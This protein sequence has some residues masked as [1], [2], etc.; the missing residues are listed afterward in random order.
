MACY[1]APLV[2]FSRRRTWLSLLAFLY[3]LATITS[4]CYMCK[5]MAFSLHHKYYN[6]Q[7]THSCKHTHIHFI[8]T[9]TNAHTHIRTHTR[10][11][12]TNKHHLHTHTHTHI[13]TYTQARTH[14]HTRTHTHINER[15]MHHH[16]TWL[17]GVVV[18]KLQC[19]VIL[20]LSRR[21]N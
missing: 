1:H 20:R 19:R 13:P 2:R 14:A 8:P 10:T 11:L 3:F 21:S 18:I 15:A 17:Y 16:V 9:R 7:P 12:Y 4:N 6:T 5:Y